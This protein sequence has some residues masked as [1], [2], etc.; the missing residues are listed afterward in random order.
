MEGVDYFS[1]GAI[2]KYEL[3]MQNAEQRGIRVRVLWLC[4]PHNPLGIVP[5]R[6]F[7]VI[8]SLTKT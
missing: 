4:N 2:E 6:G 7:P 8:F 1:S 5:T 3:S